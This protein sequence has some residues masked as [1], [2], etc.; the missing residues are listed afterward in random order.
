MALALWLLTYYSTECVDDVLAHITGDRTAAGL[1]PL[2]QI[3]TETAKSP[4]LQDSHAEF[5]SV[6]AAGGNWGR[7]LALQDVASADHVVS[8][9]R[10]ER[11]GTRPRCSCPLLLTSGQQGSGLVWQM[12]P[13]MDL[14][15]FARQGW[16]EGCRPAGRST[17]TEQC[18]NALRCLRTACLQESSYPPAASDA[19]ASSKT[20]R[21]MPLPD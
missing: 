11:E 8:R 4:A 9:Q 2:V 15:Q 5:Q 13:C 3:G 6:A 21:S 7:R 17:M 19:P 14:G 20:H 16:A 1:L 12:Q 10:H 18:N